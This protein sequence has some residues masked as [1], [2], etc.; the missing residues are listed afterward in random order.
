[1]CAWNMDSGNSSNVCQAREIL[2]DTTRDVIITPMYP[3]SLHPYVGTIRWSSRCKSSTVFMETAT[4]S[5]EGSLNHYFSLQVH[6][7]ESP[8]R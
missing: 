7:S 5:G 4:V 1:M 6:L 2:R 3:T 8:S